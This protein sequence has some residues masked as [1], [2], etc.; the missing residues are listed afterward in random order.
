MH[1]TSWKTPIR[2]GDVTCPA[3]TVEIRDLARGVAGALFVSLPLLFTLEMWEIAKVIP[4]A[5]LLAFLVVTFFLN[6]SYLDFAGFRRNA[7]Q[8]SK[9]WDSVVTLG[10]GI[11]TSTLTLSVSGIIEPSLDLYLTAKTVALEAIPTSIGA[12]VA[13]NQLGGGDGAEAIEVGG[14]E[15]EVEIPIIGQNETVTFVV[16]SPVRVATARHRIVS[17][18]A[19]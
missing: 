8:K 17:Y 2:D 10:I 9:W 11:V 19:P 5:A 16:A 7:W 3:G 6:K 15:H 18:V 1:A 12:A 14:E 13:I 4:D